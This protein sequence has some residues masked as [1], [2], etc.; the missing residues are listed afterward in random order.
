MKSNE[1]CEQAWSKIASHFSEF[2]MLKNGKILKRVSSNK[3]LNFFI[4]FQVSRKNYE[5]SIQFS[6]HFFIE[7]K[8]MK[9][10]GVN[11]GVV[12]GGELK[13][14]INRGR[15]FRWFELS[16]A[17]YQHSV[18]EVTQLL[19]HYIL[20]ICNDFEDIESSIDTVLEK[21]NTST[22]LFYYVY[23]FGGKEKAERCLQNFINHSSLKKKYKAFYKSLE[24][25]EKDKIDIYHSEFVGANMIKFAYLNG[26]KISQ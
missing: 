11:N 6:V 17:S 21:N 7:S 22:D 20:P 25:S 3:D 2:K 1:V 4:S 15:S 5:Y 16:G 10:E 9:K 12:Y 26:I 24:N 23:C 8:R 18:E 19:K 14:I 13:T